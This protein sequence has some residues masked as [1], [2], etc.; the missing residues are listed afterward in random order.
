VAICN[1][2]S[3]GEETDH[4]YN[5]KVRAGDGK[6]GGPVKSLGTE[7]DNCAGTRGMQ[8]MKTAMNKTGNIRIT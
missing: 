8:R 6:T 1:K 2:T 4:G 5:S 3:V 7:K